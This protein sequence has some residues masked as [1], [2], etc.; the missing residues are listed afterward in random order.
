MGY[1]TII[2]HKSTKNVYQLTFNKIRKLKQ[3]HKFK[4]F[5][6]RKK[7]NKK[8]VHTWFDTE[9]STREVDGGP[10]KGLPITGQ[11]G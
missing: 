2:N 10:V 6:E 8:K 3:L 11:N 5:M 1:C 7:K 4:T 9:C